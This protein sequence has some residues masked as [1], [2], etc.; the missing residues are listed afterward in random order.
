MYFYYGF[1]FLT[2]EQTFKCWSSTAG[3]EAC[4]ASEICTSSGL[5]WHK[6]TSDIN[7]LVNWQ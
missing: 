6:N 4:T 2:L 7:Y 5:E 1:G 3:F